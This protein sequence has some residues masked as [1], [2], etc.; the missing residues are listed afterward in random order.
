MLSGAAQWVEHACGHGIEAVL[1]SVHCKW[2][3]T[4]LLHA[5]Q[6]LHQLG[7]GPGL[8]GARVVDASR[9]RSSSES[10]EAAVQSGRGSQGKGL[11]QR[12][13]KQE[14]AELSRPRTLSLA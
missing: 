2:Q 7:Q 10:A 12:G 9:L 1:R 13:L 6:H 8:A 11:K 14:A 5:L 3:P 4:C